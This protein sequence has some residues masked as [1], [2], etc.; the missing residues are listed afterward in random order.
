LIGYDL[1]KIEQLRGDLKDRLL[2]D[3]GLEIHGRTF[4]RLYDDL[5][6]LLP[7]CPVGALRDTLRTMVGTVL[8]PPLVEEWAY[9][10]AGNTHRLIMGEVLV[11]WVRQVADEWVPFQF[12][13]ARPR[14]AKN[15]EPGFV[16]ECSAQAGG[17][18]PIRLE[19]HCSHRLCRFLSRELG[20]TRPP[21]THRPSPY[22][23]HEARE[24][25]GLYFYGLVP[26]GATREKPEFTKIRGT[27][28][29]HTLNRA[30]LD[31]RKKKPCKTAGYSH[32]CVRCTIGL[33]R[34]PAATHARSY[35]AG[36][37]RRCRR[38][39]VPVD[40]RTPDVCVNC[41]AKPERS[42]S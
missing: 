19:R 28:A 15:G 6:P 3:C 14:E 9:R 40:P 7:D 22:P 32:A 16:F 21:S 34:C 10:I 12:T 4:T 27:T 13:D 17:P 37:C 29:T 35:A 36:S 11:P 20:F 25:V 18:C 38:E 24:L 5:R 33:D 30:V 26:K 2:A 8:M 23:F 31:L 41:A 39:H 1:R 42:S